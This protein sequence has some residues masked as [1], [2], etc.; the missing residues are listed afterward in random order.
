[1]IDRARLRSAAAPFVIT[2]AACALALVPVRTQ[3]SKGQAPSAAPPPPVEEVKLAGAEV[4]ALLDGLREG[5]D[6]AGFRVRRVRA[7]R[8]RIVAVEV[9][10][11]GTEISLTVA[12]RG[13]VP[14]N[15]PRSTAQYDLFYDQHRDR[16]VPFET[17]A[18]PLGALGDRIA[19]VEARV[20]RPPGM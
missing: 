1:M 16:A 4:I 2:V 5:D 15:A 18:A 14:H 10:K 19:R 3:Q 11:D 13:V 9:E 17:I 6:L 12:A 7:P 8:D 20:P